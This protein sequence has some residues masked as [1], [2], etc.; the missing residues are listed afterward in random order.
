VR[1]V[2]LS[3]RF[4]NLFH[5]LRTMKQFHIL[6]RVFTRPQGTLSDVMLVL[7]EKE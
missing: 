7:A 1:E 3:S 2:R 4:L 6:R 5:A